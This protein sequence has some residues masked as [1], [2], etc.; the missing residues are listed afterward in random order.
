[1]AICGTSRFT[2][3]ASASTEKKPVFVTA[4]F[5]DRNDLFIEN[6]QQNEIE[7]FE[8]DQP[9]TI[10]FMAR[11]ELPAVYGIIFEHA[12]LP[13]VS[14]REVSGLQSRSNATSARDIA[15][16]LIDKFLAHQTLWVGAYDRELEVV[17]DAAPDGFGAKNALG[18]LRG[19]RAQTPSFLFPA[20][21]S[22]VGKMS[23]RHEKRRV[24]ILFLESVDS[25]TA[26]RM[27]QLKNLLASSNVELFAI[28]FVSRLGVPGSMPSVLST[29]L[30]RELTQAT[31]GQAFFSIDYRDHPEDIVR[32]LLSHLRTFYT[33]GFHSE[34]ESANPGKLTI[35]CSRPSTRIKQHPTIPTLE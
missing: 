23:Q 22:A 6:L 2:A 8:N 26:G 30:L 19:G 31:A 24:I 10:E 13:D 12:M 34:S 28:S 17:F 35:K 7:I 5:L 20:L 16:E 33:F 21:F 15:Y 32:R 29:T 27:K 3:P 14:E 25:E 4:S 18:Q 11:D 9:R 1:M